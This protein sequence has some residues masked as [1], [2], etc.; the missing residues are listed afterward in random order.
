MNDELKIYM[1]MMKEYYLQDHENLDGFW[2]W[3][4][5]TQKLCELM[6]D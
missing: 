3:F 1:E 5:T 4:E 6:C 2:E